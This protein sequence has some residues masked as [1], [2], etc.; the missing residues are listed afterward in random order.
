MRVPSNAFEQYVALGDRRSYESLGRELG[1]SKRAITR[2]A[3]R[4]RWQERM[5]AIESTAQ[6][7]ALTRIG[8]DLAGI[9]ERQ[10]R[11]VRAVEARALETLR[12]KPIAT[13]DQAVR[14]LLAAQREER[15]LA[16]EVDGAG[17]G[18]VLVSVERGTRERFERRTVALKGPPQALPAT[19][20]TVLPAGGSTEQT[21]DC[22]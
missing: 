15:R 7:Q 13:A 2:T 17:A 11:A 19:T 8:E 14:A 6:T 4:E 12:E 10:L 20:A 22:P 9:R 21:E 1:F 5:R 16:G 3:A 18:R